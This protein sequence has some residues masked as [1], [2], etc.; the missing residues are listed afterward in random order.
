MSFNIGPHPFVNQRI[1]VLQNDRM[2]GFLSDGIVG[3]SLFKDYCVE[4]DYDYMK[5]FLHDS[6]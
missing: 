4:I 2:K 1:I 5:L 3:Y 6:L